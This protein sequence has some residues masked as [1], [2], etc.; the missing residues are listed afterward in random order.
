MIGLGSDK[1]MFISSRSSACRRK[2]GIVLAVGSHGKPDEVFINKSCTPSHLSI[3]AEKRG[4][5][6]LSVTTM[7]HGCFFFEIVDFSRSNLYL[8]KESVSLFI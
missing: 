7:C 3:A 8:L 4:V 6:F 2:E 1:N 5:N